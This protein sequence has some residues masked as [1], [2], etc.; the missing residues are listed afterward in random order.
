MIQKA[1][2][3]IFALA[4]IALS[5]NTQ[6]ASPLRL[7]QTTTLPNVQG[8][9]DHF[10]VDLAGQRLFMS[11]LGNNTL[12]VFDLRTN[13]LIHTIRGLHEPQGVTYASASHRIFVANGDDGT[14]RIFDGSTYQLLKTLHFSSDADD[15]RYDAATRHVVLG[16]GDESNAGLAI[17]DGATG[18]VLEII[19]LPAHPESFQLEQSRPLI[20]VNIPS[21]GN[22]VDVVDRDKRQIVATW[23]LGGAQDNFPMALD[24]ARHRLFIGCRTP[25]EVLVL[26]TDSGKIIARLPSVTHADDLWYDAAHK[27]IYVSGGGGFIT[28]IAQL[29]PNHYQ[30]VAQIQ[31]LSGART[32]CLVPQLNRFYLGVW[33]HPARPA[34]L[35]VYAIQP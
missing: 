31:T 34:Q 13:K 25:A 19:K 5:G 11:A 18:D 1:N 16:F 35:R 29:D 10:D 15:T 12:E 9:M 24:E 26:D 4:L 2:I 33:G 21:A 30:R 7:L 32:S 20:Y 27:R 23:T 6:Q 28:V 14:V 17:L 3:L 22:I 8:R